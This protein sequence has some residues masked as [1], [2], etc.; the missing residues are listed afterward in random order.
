M[1]VEE[2]YARST[3]KCLGGKK[4]GRIV[5]V[6]A[7]RVCCVILSITLVR[8]T[9]HLHSDPEAVARY[10]VGAVTM[11]MSASPHGTSSFGR[12][13]SGFRGTVWDYYRGLAGT[14]RTGLCHRRGEVL[15][16]NQVPPPLT[17]FGR[18]V[19]V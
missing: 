4:P 14:Q 2:V 5:S 9:N 3:G 18:V 16:R 7:Y 11:V 10:A 17:T 1:D 12:E 13:H 19:S 6:S 15:G 8:G